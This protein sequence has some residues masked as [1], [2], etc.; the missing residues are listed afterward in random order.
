MQGTGTTAWVELAA[1][2]AKGEQRV[3]PLWTPC[4]SAFRFRWGG[5]GQ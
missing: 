5:P 4:A 3:Q 2:W 1:G